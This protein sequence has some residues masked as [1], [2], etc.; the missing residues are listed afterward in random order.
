MF[1]F[2]HSKSTLSIVVWS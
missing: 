2:K 1:G